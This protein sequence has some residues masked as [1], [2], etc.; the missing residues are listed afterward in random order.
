MEVTAAIHAV[1]SVCRRVQQNAAAT[2]MCM[3]DVGA[4]RTLPPGTA[5][6]AASASADP[7]SQLVPPFAPLERRTPKRFLTLSDAPARDE[8]RGVNRIVDN[9]SKK[10]RLT[11][12]STSD[13]LVFIQVSLTYLDIPTCFSSKQLTNFSVVHCQGGY[14]PRRRKG[15]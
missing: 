15:D 8:V 13:G 14:I 3:L 1:S 7:A 5:W 10:Q 6:V 9:V 11:Y 12:A 4:T 2:A